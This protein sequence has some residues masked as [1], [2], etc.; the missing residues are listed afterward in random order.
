[1]V[2]RVRKYKGTTLTEKSC[3][4]KRDNEQRSSRHCIFDSSQ[5]SEAGGR[6]GLVSVHV[7]DLLHIEGEKHVE[8]EDLV[9]PDDPLLLRLLPQPARPFRCCV[10]L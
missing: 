4:V 1:M 8:E 2:V 7:D 9:A 5:G 6:A 3:T 10:L